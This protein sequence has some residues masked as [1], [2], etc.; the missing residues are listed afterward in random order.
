MSE[1]NEPTELK[2]Y[3]PK[4]VERSWQTLW[5]ERGTNRVDLDAAADPFYA[6]MM[7]PYPS[8]EGL[9]VGNL[10]AFTG[11]DVFGRF[12]RCLLYTSPSPRD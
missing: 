4:A 11:A 6:L 12:K 3:D 2:V 1:S 9:H 8:A 10:F 7:F 5:A